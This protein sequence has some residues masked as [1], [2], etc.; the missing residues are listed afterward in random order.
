MLVSSSSINVAMVTVIAISQGL[1][2]GLAPLSAFGTANGSEIACVPTRPSLVYTVN[3][4]SKK[5]RTLYA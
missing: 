4:V 2:T 3:Y 5:M 1:M